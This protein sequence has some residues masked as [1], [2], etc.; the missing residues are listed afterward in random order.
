ML[1]KGA[2]AAKEF[3]E[4]VADKAEDLFEE[5]EE[6]IDRALERKPTYLERAKAL[7]KMVGEGQLLEAFDLYYADDVV[8]Q[9][10]T[11]EVYEGKA[12][13]RQRGEQ[14]LASVK[15]MHGGGTHAITANEATKVTMVEAWVDFTMQDGNR[16]KM[17]EVAVQ[18]WKD[19]KIIHER[20]YYN[21]P[22]S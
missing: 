13:N 3:A 15:E 1:K 10:A 14:W 12:T 4:D 20:F 18:R 19:G 8:M 11:G 2:D 17:E 21:A 9:E 6:A 5:A 7:Y 16:M 22:S